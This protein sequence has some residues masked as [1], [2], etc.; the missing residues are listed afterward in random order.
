M[1][2][3]AKKFPKPIRELIL[4]FALG[5]A[6]ILNGLRGGSRSIGVQQATLNLWREIMTRFRTRNASQQF[7]RLR[8]KKHLKLHLGCGPD[9]RS[10]WVN[11]DVFVT[12]SQSSDTYVIQYDLRQPIPLE[13]DS[14]SYVYS[15]HFFEH[16]SCD[17]GYQLMKDAYRWLEKGGI[18][19]I[20][21]P[22]FE[23]VFKAY[24]NGDRAYFDIM[25]K[26]DIVPKSPFQN[27]KL[28]LV[29]FVNYSVYQV[30]QHKCIYDAETLMDLLKSIGYSTVK[31]SEFDANVDVNTDLRKQYTF[32]VEAQK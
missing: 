2:Q 16:L 7:D 22:D 9:I 11:M 24:I 18:F 30:D 13:N 19:R 8:G 6:V 29:D 32:Y 31:K 10:G 5:G 4:G 27:G 12:P 3:T 21:L 28:A 26:A 14:L 23:S 15:S 20:A 17:D 25:E 1:Y